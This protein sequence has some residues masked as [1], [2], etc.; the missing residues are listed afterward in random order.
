MD[1]R[2]LVYEKEARFRQA[3]TTQLASTAGY[4]VLG[5]YESTKEL[6]A[7]VQGLQP[8]LV[9]LD[10]ELL[11]ERAAARPRPFLWK[12]LPLERFIVLSDDL[13]ERVIDAIGAGMSGYLLKKMPP[14]R[15]LGAIR[16]IYGGA[17]EW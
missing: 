13:D 16:E 7:Q 5:A 14:P 1:V 8:H 15:I 6:E 3:L 17:D 11:T 4:A 10:I 9:L 2:I 12:D